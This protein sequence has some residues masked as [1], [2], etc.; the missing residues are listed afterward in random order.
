MSPGGAVLSP[1]GSPALEIAEIGWVMFGGAALLFVATMALLL[2]WSV[3]RPR[4]SAAPGRG[5]RL[6]PRRRR[7]PADRRARGALF[8][9]SHWRAL[10]ARRHPRPAGR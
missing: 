4:A 1:S 7:G 3:R 10:P 6:D 2:A 9:Y 8:L 5:S